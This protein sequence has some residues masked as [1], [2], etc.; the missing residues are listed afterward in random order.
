MN[1]HNNQY[2]RNQQNKDIFVSNFSNQK[3]I[4]SRETHQKTSEIPKKSLNFD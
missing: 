3:S 1:S 4:N 2:L